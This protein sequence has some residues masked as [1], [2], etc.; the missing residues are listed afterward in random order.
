VQEE[1]T[2]Y[3][4]PVVTTNIVS[5]ARHVVATPPAGAT[6]PTCAVETNAGLH[7]IDDTLWLG[8][9]CGV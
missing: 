3:L 4:Q 6:G 1:E 5:A 2:I 8:S 7:A 9:K